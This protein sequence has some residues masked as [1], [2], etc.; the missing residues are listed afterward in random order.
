MNT[1]L[2]SVPQ[3]IEQLRTKAAQWNVTLE[4]T[5]ETPS[6]LLGFGVHDGRRVVLKL[7]K[8]AGD[9]ARSGQVLRAFGAAGAV[10]VYE[11]EVGAVLLERLDPGEELVS[12]VRRGDDDQATRILA[13]VIAR[14]KDHEAPAGTMTVA[15]YGR[16]FDWY[17]RTDDRQVPAE[18]VREAHADYADLAAT[19]HTTMLLHGDLQHYNV[20]CD[21]KRGWLAIDPKGVVGELEYEVGALMRNPIELPEL[22][23]S[24]A[25]IERRLEILT[26][27]LPLDR[28]RTLRWCFAQAVLSAVWGVEDGYRIERDH[29]ALRLA[30]TLKQMID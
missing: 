1:R 16:A 18:L 15:E 6:S 24:R 25:T 29:G 21:N 8:S 2:K 30:L 3:F 22:Y 5:R 19:Q 27:L 14:L 28:S 26:S 7:T 20:L 4:G 9:E 10:R 17:V 12:L 13:D 23:T 11:A